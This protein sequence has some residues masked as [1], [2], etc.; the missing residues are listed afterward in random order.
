M[1]PGYLPK[2]K[3]LVVPDQSEVK[4]EASKIEMFAKSGQTK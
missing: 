3:K 1:K 2:V 4:S